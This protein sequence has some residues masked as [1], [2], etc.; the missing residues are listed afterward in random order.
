MAHKADEIAPPSN[1]PLTKPIGHT[2]V[3]VDDFI[4]LGQGSPTCMRTLRW[5]LFHAVDQVLAKPDVSADQRRE[6]LSLKKMMKGD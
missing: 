2:D 5:H 4:Q 6:A 3:F 1:C